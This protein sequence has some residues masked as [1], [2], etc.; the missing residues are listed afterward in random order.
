MQHVQHSNHD[1]TDVL[2]SYVCIFSLQIFF[3]TFTKSDFA[4]H[5]MFSLFLVEG[6]ISCLCQT[7]WTICQCKLTL[8]H[9]NK[10]KRLE[11]GRRGCKSRVL[12]RSAAE[13]TPSSE[14]RERGSLYDLISI[15][16]SRSKISWKYP[17]SNAGCSRH[18]ES[19][20]V[21][22]W[23]WACGLGFSALNLDIFAY[24]NLTFFVS[25]LS[26]STANKTWWMMT[27]LSPTL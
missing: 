23:D 1:S 14:E 13:I 26:V 16:C 7:R 4:A 24:I 18:I 2:S 3:E 12:I 22:D 15:I 11:K 10:H 5:F 27:L 8:S 20:W 9:F 25:C 17:E 21:L 6:H 19:M